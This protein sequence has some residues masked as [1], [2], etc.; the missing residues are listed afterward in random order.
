MGRCERFPTPRLESRPT[1]PGNAAYSLTPEEVALLLPLPA[2]Q[3]AVAG[4]VT[5]AVHRH[6]RTDAQQ[7]NL[8]QVRQTIPHQAASKFPRRF[9]RRLDGRQRQEEGQWG[10][11]KAQRAIAGVPACHGLVL[12]V[13]QQGDAAHLLA[14]AQTAPASRQQESNQGCQLMKSRQPCASTADAPDTRPRSS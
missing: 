14:G 5:I 2:D 11:E 4:A 6:R 3:D 1:Q 12:G 13:N 7:I 9:Q 8:H 10:I